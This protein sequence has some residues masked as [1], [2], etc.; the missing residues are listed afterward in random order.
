MKIDAVIVEFEK[1]FF[2]DLPQIKGTAGR[3]TT[4]TGTYMPY[5]R[6]LKKVAGC[7]DLS[8]SI[9]MAALQTY[10]PASRSKQMA[11]TVYAR[12][13]RATGLQLPDGWNE[14]VSEY[15]PPKKENENILI[16]ESMITSCLDKIP[17]QQWRNVFALIAVY[18]LKNY[19]P[20]FVDLEHFQGSSTL[21]AKI[22]GADQF[23]D[24]LVWPVPADWATRFGIN[25][26]SCIGDLPP[27]ATDLSITTLQ[28]IGR[29]SAEQFRRYGLHFTPSQLRHSWAARAINTGVPDSLA[30]KMLGMDPIFYLKT[31][32]IEIQKRDESLF[33]SF[34]ATAHVPF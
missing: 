7:D 17:S 1:A 26:I 24:R 27:I 6:R 19:E 4:W 11:A 34:S 13:A 28:Q 3:Q 32:Q 33:E 5:L 29:R 2:A 10:K 15:E 14:S 16:D 21:I 23:N 25:R 18:G 8:A 30:A 12:L 9:F 22:C 31:Y 20:F